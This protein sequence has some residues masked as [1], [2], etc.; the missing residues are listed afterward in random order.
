[1]SIFDRTGNFSQTEKDKMFL[2]WQIH[3]GLQ[4]TVHSI[5]EAVTYL[6]GIE[7]SFVLKERFSQDS[8]EEYFSKHRSIGHRND[9][10]DLYHFGYNSNTIRM[11]RSIAPVTGN[12]RRGYKHK[13]RVS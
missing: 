3:E 8:L 6:L 2:S 5:I 1:M 7:M 9:N 13:R 10:Q 11:H 12:T 4:I